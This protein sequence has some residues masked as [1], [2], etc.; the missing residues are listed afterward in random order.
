MLFQAFIPF[1]RDSLSD[2]TLLKDVNFVIFLNSVTTF[3]FM[4]MHQNIFFVLEFCQSTVYFFTSV[5]KLCFYLLSSIH[6]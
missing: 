5:T 3:K 4:K 6:V 1:H 2:L